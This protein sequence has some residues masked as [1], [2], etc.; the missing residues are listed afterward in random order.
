[1][2]KTKTDFLKIRSLSGLEI[3]TISFLARRMKKQKKFMEE[4]NNFLPNL[5]F[6]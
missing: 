5:K 1:M 4:I 3:L 2:D 6:T